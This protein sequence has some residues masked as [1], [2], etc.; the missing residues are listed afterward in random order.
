MKKIN[1]NVNDAMKNVTFKVKLKGVN[2]LK[3]RLFIGIR[4][5]M[6]A[7]FIIGAGIEFDTEVSDEN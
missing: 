4:L 3:V 6:L 5:L 2:V 1:V 7:A